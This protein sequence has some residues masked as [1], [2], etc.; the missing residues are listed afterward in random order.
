MTME[1]LNIYLNDSLLET[2]TKLTY[3]SLT[4]S[5]QNKMCFSVINSIGE[6]Y[7]SSIT[8]YACDLPS[9]PGISTINFFN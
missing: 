9:K 8:F 5:Y 6:S 2:V 4:K 7:P 3:S 1:I